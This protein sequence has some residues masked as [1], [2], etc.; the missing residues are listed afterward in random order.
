MTRDFQNDEWF[1]LV[2]RFFGEKKRDIITKALLFE[3]RVPSL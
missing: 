3:N 2:S 1:I